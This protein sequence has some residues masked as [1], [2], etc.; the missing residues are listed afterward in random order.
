MVV[1]TNE[2]IHTK[3]TFIPCKLT[4]YINIKQKEILESMCSRKKTDLRIN[5][6]GD[7]WCG[8]G[9]G[10]TERMGGGEHRSPESGGD[11]WRG[12]PKLRWEEC[13]NGENE[14]KIGDWKLLIEKLV[15]EN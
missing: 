13:R 7:D 14:Q 10:R 12:T 4:K 2:A 5:W 15:Q 3:N 6:L 1:I 9:G 8:L 11:R